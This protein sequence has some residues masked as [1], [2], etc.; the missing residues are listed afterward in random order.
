MQPPPWKPQRMFL[1]GFVLQC[2]LHVRKFIREFMAPGNRS[3]YLLRPVS[4]EGESK[5]IFNQGRKLYSK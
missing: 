1:F 4:S 3:D 5:L 2:A